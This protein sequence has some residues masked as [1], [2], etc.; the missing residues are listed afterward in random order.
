MMHLCRC[1][2]AWA[3]TYIQGHRSEFCANEIGEL[4]ACPS[5]SNPPEVPGIPGETTA[6]GFAHA[7]IYPRLGGWM[8][9]WPFRQTLFTWQLREAL[10]YAHQ[11]N[12]Q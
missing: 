5:C 8:V 4:V 11:L 12:R 1:G 10:A 9:R 3:G 7:F 6:R 2:E